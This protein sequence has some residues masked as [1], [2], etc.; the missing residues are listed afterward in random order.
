MISAL[1]LA[2]ATVTPRVTHVV[3]FRFKAD[4]ASRAQIPA[5]VQ[6]FK[7]LEAQSVTASDPPHRL[8]TALH[9]GQNDSLEQL[10][11]GKKGEAQD[12]TTEFTF[13]LTFASVADR[14]RYVDRDPAHQAF[15]QLVGPLLDGGTDGVFVTDFEE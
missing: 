3:A 9:A 13:V 14:D 1:I 7:D 11:F 12:R 8:I 5:V 4:D 6:A 2:L 10:S 15:K